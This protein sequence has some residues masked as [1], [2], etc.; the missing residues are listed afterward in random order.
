[1]FTPKTCGGGG[2]LVLFS[3]HLF[4]FF[5]IA[6]E[7]QATYHTYYFVDIDPISL[8]DSHIRHP[9]QIAEYW[10]S[11]QSQILF[12]RFQQNSFKYSNATLA[13]SSSWWYKSHTLPQK[14]HNAN[15]FPTTH[16]NNR[17]NNTTTNFHQ[18][19]FDIYPTS[20]TILQAYWYK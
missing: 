16:L 1:M 8:V 12:F 13:N 11:D 5:F 17:H 2:D 4:F 15:I 20:R 3:D 18:K 19:S 10:F 14:Y 7:W 6:G 9:R